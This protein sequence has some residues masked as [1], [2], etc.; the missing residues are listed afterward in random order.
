MMNARWWVMGDG[1]WVV[2]DNDAG[3]ADDVDDDDEEETRIR[4][5]MMM[6]NG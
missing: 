4:I 1:R 5:V 6:D 2:D 3:Y